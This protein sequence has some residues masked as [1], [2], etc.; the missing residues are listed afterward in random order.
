MYVCMYLTTVK[1]LSVAQGRC[2]IESDQE[3]EMEGS[4]LEGLGGRDSRGRVHCYPFH[5]GLVQNLAL[6]HRRGSKWDTCRV[7]EAKIF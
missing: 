7:V 2:F 6:W 3:N 4:E 1:Y 5:V